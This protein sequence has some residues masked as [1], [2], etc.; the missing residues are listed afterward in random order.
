MIEIRATVGWEEPLL[1]IQR[2]HSEAM[3]MLCILSKARITQ[4]Y[5]S[6]KAEQ[7]V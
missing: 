5:A 2:E 7:T 3:K 4:F 1:E 6:V